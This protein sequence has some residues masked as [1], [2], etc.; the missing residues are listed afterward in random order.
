MSGS[1]FLRHIPCENCGSSDGNS[2]YSDGHQFCF[3]CNTDVQPKGGG[4]ITKE[5]SKKLIP[6]EDLVYQAIPKRKLREDTCSHFGYGIGTY[7]GKKVQVAPYYDKSGALVGQKLRFP[8]KTF[9]VLG[10]IKDAM[11]FGFHC[12][13]R[14]GKRVVVTEGEIDA[15][16]M[17]QVQ[18]NKWPVVSIP[19]GVQGAKKTIAKHRDYFLGF[20][21][22]VLVFDQDEPGQKAVQECAAVLGGRAKIAAL[23]LKDPNEMLLA[24]RVDEL[25]T[26]VWR[27]EP[28][29]PEGIVKGSELK[30]RVS[31]KPEWGLSW[32][33]DTLTKYTYGIR[34]TELIALGAGVGVGKTDLL[35]QQI[36]HFLF[37]HKENV[38]AFFL[39]ST[40]EDLMRRMLGKHAGKQFHLPDGDWTEDD[41]EAAWKDYYSCGAEVF[42]YD[43][44]GSNKWESIREKIEYLYHAEGVRYFILDH[45]TAL[46]AEE[47]DER[48][49]LDAIMAEMGG[50]V[51]KL[52]IALIFVSHLATPE[53]GSHE[54]GAQVQARHFRGSRAIAQW[55]SFMIGLERNQQADDEE[56]RHTTTVRIIKDRYTGKA[57]GEKFRLGYDHATG[58]L[59][60]KDPIAETYF[61]PSGDEKGDF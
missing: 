39:E 40:C 43:S 13:P 61:P 53:R 45:L 33:C 7:N 21:E 6:P 41:L 18:G 16:T 17:S 22:V 49:A 38:G 36:H 52:G 26:A 19:N 4:K 37:H 1:E 2:L 32:F 3:V 59:Y 24:G 50:L 54:E 47:E 34:T 15:L 11:P 51:K 48:R 8:D 35:T 27:A 25:V 44:F 23:P 9:A 30:E 31:K 46:A 28:Y 10:S 5:A 29:R 58:R 42:L 20:D 12:W 14:T 55:S 60:E 57:T 56:E